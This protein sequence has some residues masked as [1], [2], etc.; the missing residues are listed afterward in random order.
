MHQANPVTLS[1]RGL[2]QAL[3]AAVL[4]PVGLL[5][6][7][8]AFADEAAGYPT[9]P[10]SVT[11]CFLPGAST[12]ALARRI[13]ERLATSLGR[14]VVV[15]NRGGNLAASRIAKAAPDGHSL[16]FCATGGLVVAA[17][18]RTPL[19]FDPQRDLATVAPAGDLAV[20]LLVRPT[21]PAQTLRE[22]VDHARANPGQ[23][24]FGSIGV[25][26]SFHLAI[27]QIN[28]AA[29]VSMTH[30]PFCGG[31]PVMLELLAGRL[32]AVFASLSLGKPHILAGTVRPLAAA[33]E[34]RFPEL[35][36]VPTLAEAGLPGIWLQ[37]RLG[38]FVPAGTPPPII[39]RLN[40][41]ISRIVAE[42]A[43]RE[44]MVS[45]G[46][47][48]SPSSPEAFRATLDE[49]TRVLGELIRKL[50]LRLE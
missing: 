28:A 6:G 30:V 14:P 43:M 3:L 37:E 15:E 1:K 36:A 9:R 46:I 38:F 4:L 27:E 35:P 48:P 13:G 40:A 10:V 23:L 39:T 24:N 8:P 29:G 21:L 50:G 2:S 19:D 41:E 47:P 49:G 31:G 11:V 20:L 7:P 32:D 25:G 42:P 44:W 22:F 26:S 45:Q 18:A 16:L 34:A 12:D 5:V 33:G 17:A